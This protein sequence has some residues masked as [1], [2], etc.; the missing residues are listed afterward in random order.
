LSSGIPV[1]GYLV[2]RYDAPTLTLQTI[3]T[4]CMGTVTTTTC[5]ESGVPTG[6]WVYSVTPVFATNWRGAESLKSNPVM[7]DS[8]PPVNALSISL[9][10]GGAFASGGTVFYRGVAAG[11][12]TLT[13]AL[14]D[15]GSGPASSSTATLSGTSTGWTH[16]ASTVATPTGGPYTSNPFGWT[17]GTVSGPTEL[18]TGRDVAG[19]TASSTLSYANDSLSPSPG[20][21][22]YLDGPQPGRSVTVTFSAGIDAG[23]GIATRQLQ[24][25]SAALTAGV[26]GTFTGFSNAGPDTPTSP[27][28][29]SLVANKTCYQY[30]YVVTDRVGNQ[31]IATSPNVS[32]VD[33]AG[34]QVSLGTAATYS[35]L[36][37]TGVVS[38][39]LTTVSGDL[40]VS[41]SNSIVGFPPGVVSGTVHAGDGPAAVAQEDLVLSYNDAAGRTPNG[42]FAGDVNGRTFKAG[43]WHTA[44]AFALTG[45]LTLD[46]QGDPNAVFIFQ[47][48]AALNTAAASTIT[49][50]N[51]A[52]ASH[53][54][55]QVV[56]A[57]ATGALSSF[58]GTIMA[59]GAIT[60]GAGTLLVGRAL[61]YG[62]VTMADNT[63]RFAI[64][65]PPAVTI[66]GGASAVTKTATPTV[67]GTTDAGTGAIVTVTVAGQTLFATTQTDNSWSVS[68]TTLPG[69]SHTVAASVRNPAGDAGSATQMLTV[70]L[71][72]APVV[73]DTAATYSVLA[74]TGVVNTG[75]TV[76]SGDLGESPGSSVVGFP[77]GVV[78]GATHVADPTAAMAQANLVAAYTDA[79]SRTPTGSF[80]G[81]VGGR[82]FTDG[83]WQTTAAFALTGTLTLDGEGDPNAVF[84]FQ[85]DAALNT[86]AGSTI[87]LINGAQASHVF[88]QVVGAAGTG[89]LSS[90]S[91]TIMAAGAITLGAGTA[92]NGRALSYGTVT[93][94]GNAVQ[95]DST[96]P[97]SAIS[98]AV[99][100]GGA[101]LNPHPL[102]GDHTGR[103]SLPTE[104]VSDHDVAG[105]VA[106]T[107]L[108]YT[109]DSTAPATS[110]GTS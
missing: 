2:K 55:W 90:F 82:T 87:T 63:V 37:G 6:Q 52:Q 24:R 71:N 95:S 59:A 5:T 85:I 14:T 69:G 84:I 11:S 51:G 31:D 45:N 91:G 13:N 68:P 20:S 43:V 97:S 12:F 78:Q 46:G 103:W 60:L 27:Y 44:S 35:V 1:T 58:S 66:T 81:D 96:P 104:V 70:A 38:T 75:L 101:T 83:V 40:G 62:T 74:G 105:N 110:T 25:A 41:P 94:A 36:A 28:V 65:P 29:D 39:G 77:P 16:S 79:A 67:T 42:S 50:I 64:G 21:I 99:V 86:A 53:V 80:A 108:T 73:L 3:L 7:T 18:V 109:N 61:S 22:T 19:N 92:L 56:G 26:C 49:L 93:M 48:D 4:A 8:T 33:F 30:R 89:A 47:V 23:S 107:T 76:L 9:G 57:A 100:T 34:A 54:F 32:K 72:P 88:W 106:T 15:S 17:A 98:S 102:D 10:T